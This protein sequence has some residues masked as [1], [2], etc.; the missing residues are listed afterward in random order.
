[1]KPADLGSVAVT[2][3]TTAETPVA[4]IPP[5]PVTLTSTVPPDRTAALGAP[6]PG[7]RVE[8]PEGGQHCEPARCGDLT[9]DVVTGDVG[10]E[11]HGAR[12]T[13]VQRDLAVGA[14]RHDHHVGH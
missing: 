10:D 4:G 5:V 9:G 7:L 12:S 8:H 6:L 14:D 11:L 13:V 2:L 1:M 3:R